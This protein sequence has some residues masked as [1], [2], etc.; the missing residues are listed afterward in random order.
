MLTRRK[1]LTLTVATT[2]IVSSPLVHAQDKWGASLGYP[3]GMAGGLTRDPGY[4]V[5]NY[6]GGFERIFPHHVIKA[7]GGSRELTSTPQADFS[8]R[9]G[10]FSKTPD[11][12]LERW[13]ATGLL[14][15]RGGNVLVE[16]YRMGRT[17][18]TRFTSW[19]M[20]KS[21]TSLL[22][23]I[24][25]DR[26]LIK[27]F[28][29][30]AEQYVPELQGTLHGSTT[31]RNLANMSSGAEVLHDRDNPS[32]YPMAFMSRQSSITRTVAAWNQRKE[33]QGRTY[34]YNELC[35]LTLGM[36][37]RKVTGMSLS[38]F[39]E[40]ALWQPMGAEADA[41]WLTDSERNEFN[42]IG[43]AARLRDWARIG[44]LVA[45]R[46]LV[47]GRQIVS[48]AWIRECTQ[49]TEKD[50]QGRVGYAMRHAGYK[51]LMWHAKSD[52]SWLYFNGHHGQRVIIDMASKTVLVQTA[53]DHEGNWQEELFAM[54][55]A[56]TKVQS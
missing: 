44:L 23:G 48:E 37:I 43:L 17:S 55:N 9:W 8:Y 1:V 45:D 2:G 35:P 20:A 54:F 14:I 26:G 7:S 11:E 41:T 21:V 6:S 24:C 5:G 49:W 46:G 18:D 27:S 39:A 52:G 33:E 3:T 25:I 47:G 10:L 31:L 13:P 22:L 12:Y 16:R 15:C 36:V 30:P 51:A 53:V 32:I 40:T 4:R 28:D 56:A 50:K 34:N 19:S 29:D 38:T 42:C